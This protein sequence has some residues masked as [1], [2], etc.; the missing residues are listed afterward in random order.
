MSPRNQPRN[1][2]GKAASDNPTLVRLGEQI[3]AQ[4]REVGR[5][6]QDVADAAGVSR[7]TLH[8]I[9]HGGAGVRWEKVVAVA[10]ELGLQ[11]GFGPQ[12][13]SALAVDKPSEERV[14]WA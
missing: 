1:K 5:L 13:E 6:Q 9:E 11:M 4:R 8:T 12:P 14:N 10:E 3:A 7:S 2:Q